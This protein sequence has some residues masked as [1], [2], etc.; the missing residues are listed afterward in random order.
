MSIEKE[1]KE[2]IPYVTNPYRDGC[3]N[4]VEYQVDFTDAVGN[5]AIITKCDF[6]NKKNKQVTG[7]VLFVRWLNP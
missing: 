6:I 3:K 2:I 1:E 7:Y 5:K 4:Q